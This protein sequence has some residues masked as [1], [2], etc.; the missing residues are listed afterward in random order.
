MNGEELRQRREQ[1]R[2]T[3]TEL[4]NVLGVYQATVSAWETGERNIRH[5]RMLDLALLAIAHGLDREQHEV[6]PQTDYESVT[7]DRERA[8]GKDGG[9]VGTGGT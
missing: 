7:G 2:L 6:R 1:L 4:A 5:P 8:G 9:N 3:Q